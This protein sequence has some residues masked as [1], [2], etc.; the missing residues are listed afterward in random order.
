MIP[1]VFE[2]SY[3]ENRGAA[4]GILQNQ[5]WIFLIATLVISLLLLRLYITLPKEKMYH[6]VRF[7]LLLILSGAVGNMIDRVGRRYVVD[8][9]YFKLIDFPVFN[10]ADCYVVIGVF[11]LAVLL[12]THR[13]MLDRIFHKGAV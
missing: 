9:L 6:P 7:S 10:L 11:L 5:R 13:D 1:G 3:V 8:F 4:F 12:L 2:F